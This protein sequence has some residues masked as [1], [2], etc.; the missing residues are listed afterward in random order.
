MDVNEWMSYESSD[1]LMRVHVLRTFITHLLVH[2]RQKK[3][4][5][6]EIAKCKPAF[7]FPE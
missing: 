7:K 1:E 5:A 4:I 3:K 6:P 2:I